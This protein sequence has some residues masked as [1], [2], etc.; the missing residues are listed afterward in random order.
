MNDHK[1]WLKSMLTGGGA[2]LFGDFLFADYSRFGRSPFTELNGPVVGLIDDVARA[3]KGNFDRFVEGKD[4]N[5]SR[6]LLRIGIRNLPLVH[7]WYARLLM[8]RLLLDNV[9]RMVDPD[10]D[11][12]IRKYERKLRKETGQEF[13]W[14]PGQM[15]PD[16]V[17]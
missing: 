4:T 6:D 9:E 14:G 10:Y 5:V 7:V 17:K 2:G 15:R 11:K 8:D 3:T 16:I 13:W 12:R 1:F